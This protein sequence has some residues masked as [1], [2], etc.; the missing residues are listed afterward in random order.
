MGVDPLVNNILSDVKIENAVGVD[1]LVNDI[2]SDVKIENAVSISSVVNNTLSDVQ[3]Q[4]TVVVTPL[5]NETISELEMKPSNEVADTGLKFNEKMYE[6]IPGIKYLNIFKKSKSNSILFL[7][8][9]TDNRPSEFITLLEKQATKYEI[10][11]INAI[12]DITDKFYLVWK[13]LDFLKQKRDQ[14]DEN[15]KKNEGYNYNL[16]RQLIEDIKKD[17]SYRSI[18][19]Q[20]FVKFFDTFFKNYFE[21]NT[22]LNTDSEKWLKKVIGYIGAKFIKDKKI[23]QKTSRSEL[24]DYIKP[25]VT[26]IISTKQSNYDYSQLLTESYLDNIYDAFTYLVYFN[27]IFSVFE[28]FRTQ[29]NNGIFF[30]NE[31]NIKIDNFDLSMRI[32]PMSGYEESMNYRLKDLFGLDKKNYKKI[33]SILFDTFGYESLIE[34]EDQT[35]SLGLKINK[36][37]DLDKLLNEKIEKEKRLE[38]EKARIV[39][40]NKIKDQKIADEVDAELNKNLSDPSYYLERDV[41]SPKIWKINDKSIRD[42]ILEKT[43]KQIEKKRDTDIEKQNKIQQSFIT[44]LSDESK[45]LDKSGLDE[46]KTKLYADLETVVDESSKETLRIEIDNY[47]DKQKNKIDKDVIIE[48]LEKEVIYN[49]S[50]LEIYKNKYKTI[51]DSITNDK[52]KSEIQDEMKTIFSEKLKEIEKAQKKKLDVY[53]AQPYDKTI[54]LG[55]YGKSII[56]LGEPCKK[57]VEFRIQN[58]DDFKESRVS[59]ESSNSS[60]DIEVELKY[61]VAVNPSEEK[62]IIVEKKIRTEKGEIVITKKELEEAYKKLIKNKKLYELSNGQFIITFNN[63]Y[64]TVNAKTVN[65][66]I[67]Q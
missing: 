42:I 58:F 32:N 38:Q 23:E 10:P 67:F 28:S 29:E 18:N 35:A 57:T 31:N 37:M 27:Y 14:Y 6:K 11:N 17:I 3:I 61:V 56:G 15:E 47:I 7:I 5:V 63:C 65:Y 12:N 2:L 51:L 20:Q 9:Q 64:S 30:L 43:D 26:E 36:N 54:E 16:K 48:A 1:P 22:I 66:K 52:L 62:E 21:Y 55:S 46:F 4:N 33:V 8:Q 39:Q 49:E 24:I 13:F 45:Q 50:A 41:L 59:F 34:E 25:F 19:N 60:F 40:E 44:V 53:Q